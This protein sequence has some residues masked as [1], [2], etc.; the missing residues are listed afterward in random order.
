MCLYIYISKCVCVCLTLRLTSEVFLLENA[1][2]RKCYIPLQICPRPDAEHKSY[3][4]THPDEE[5]VLF[6]H[7]STP[8]IY[9]R[10]HLRELH[11]GSLGIHLYITGFSSRDKYIL[12]SACLATFRSRYNIL[13]IHFVASQR[14]VTLDAEDE[15]ETNNKKR[16]NINDLSKN[17]PIP[18]IFTDKFK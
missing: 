9:S 11:C 6:N 14:S 10:H 18:N 5:D 7:A 3:A 16:R 8:F 4:D 2:G 13:L 17:K 12:R 1:P 15:G